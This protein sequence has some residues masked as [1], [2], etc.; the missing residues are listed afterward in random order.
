[1]P[2]VVADERGPGPVE[3]S[4]RREGDGE[5]PSVGRWAERRAPRS[6]EPAPPADPAHGGRATSRWPARSHRP[7][8]RTRCWPSGDAA[9]R[10]APP[11]RQIPAQGCQRGQLGQDLRLDQR[12]MMGPRQGQHSVQLRG[13]HERCHPGR[14]MRRAGRPLPIGGSRRRRAAAPARRALGRW[15]AARGNRPAATSPA[16][17]PR[18]PAPPSG[19]PRRHERAP[20]TRT[21][22]T[23]PGQGRH[24]CSPMPTCPAPTIGQPGPTA[25]TP[26]A[27]FS[28]RTSSG[29]GSM[30]GRVH[31]HTPPVSPRAVTAPVANSESPWSAASSSASMI[32]S[33]AESSAPLR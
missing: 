13:R 1:M 28:T 7:N 29:A 31:S 24:R 17:E 33:W 32:A 9:N 6:P 11:Q 12:T 27:T 25:P 16:S 23:R 18:E 26:A 4:G 19:H 8:P 14:A 10:S 22:T 20:T 5:P 21:T 30:S 15:P 3:A 2:Q